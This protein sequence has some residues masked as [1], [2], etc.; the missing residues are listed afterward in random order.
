VEIFEYSSRVGA[1]GGLDL[2]VNLGPAQAN[3]EVKIVVQPIDVETPRSL[4]EDQGLT[5]EQGPTQE[6]WIAFVNRTAGSIDDPSFARQDQGQVE[7]R[8]EIFP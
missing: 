2:H 6:Q 8:G 1:D 7:E 3:R 4:S 5:P